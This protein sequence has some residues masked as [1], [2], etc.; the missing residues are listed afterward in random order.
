MR[1]FIAV[2]ILIFSLQ[3]WTKADDIRDFEIEGISLGDSALDFFSKTQIIKGT[4][5]HYNDKTFTTVENNKLAFFKTYDAVDFHYKTDD[6]DY[7]IY[8]VTGVLYFIKNIEACYSKM[9]EITEEL[10]E[11]FTNANFLEK[12]VT[13]SPWDKNTI[14]TDIIFELES[15]NITVACYDYSKEDE[16]KNMDHLAIELFTNELRYWRRDKAYK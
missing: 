9:D 15:G 12:T 5:D 2:F 7:K 8:G 3:S 6:K 13:P 14:K 11:V 4:R 16:K 10:S 1:L